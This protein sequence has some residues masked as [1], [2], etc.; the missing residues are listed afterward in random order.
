M[1]NSEQNKY[2]YINKKKTTNKSNTWKPKKRKAFKNKL[3]QT[4]NKQN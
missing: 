3:A 1:R 2:I 4:T